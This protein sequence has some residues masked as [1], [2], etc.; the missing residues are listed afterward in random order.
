MT[1]FPKDCGSSL[2]TAAVPL[3]DQQIL[4]ALQIGKKYD[5]SQAKRLICHWKRSAPSHKLEVNGRS[6]WLLAAWVPS[7][8]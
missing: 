7:H 2:R 1:L 3:M 6:A 8:L 4:N 5:E